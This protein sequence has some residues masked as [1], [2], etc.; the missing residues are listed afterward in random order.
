MLKIVKEKVGPSPSIQCETCPKERMADIGTLEIYYNLMSGHQFCDSNDMI[1]QPTK[2]P[3]IS[4][5]GITL[6]KLTGA[7]KKQNIDF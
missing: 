6:T 3:P 1:F 4:Q 5:D 7:M 2:C